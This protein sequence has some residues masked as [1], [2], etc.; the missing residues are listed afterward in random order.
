MNLKSRVSAIAFAVGT[1]VSFSA[2]AEDVVHFYNWSDYIDEATLPNF[3]EETGISVVYDVFDSNEVLEAKL[4]SGQSGF[5]L[6][7]PTNDFLGKQIQA[8]AF[9]PLDREQLPNWSNLDPQMMAQ[10][11][12]VD[13]GNQYAVPYMWG[14]TGI[15]INEDKVKAALGEDA[16]INS[17]SLVFEKEY[18]EKLESCGVVALDAPTEV[19]S[20]AM[21]YL[22]LDPN[23]TDRDDI[24]Q[25][26]DLLLDIRPHYRYFHSSKYINDLANGDICVVIGWSGD[27]AQAAARAEEADNGVNVSYIIP[28][29]GAL[30]WFDMLAIPRDAK[31]PEGAHTL[32]NYLMRPEVTA[33]ITNYVWYANANPASMPMVDPEVANDESIFPTPEVREKL[34]LP[35]VLDQRTTRTIT[36]SWNKIKTGQ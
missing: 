8:G 3:E 15:G 1:V 14:T 36:R 18:L 29:E 30:M 28:K 9:M 4:L 13:P 24:Q 7:V 21:N 23:S 35:K 27:I 34:W 16:P 5:D 31:N 20:S 2:Q 22:G 19:M 12:T 11:E 17:W 32:I 26:T 33:D 6:V 10:L 25:A